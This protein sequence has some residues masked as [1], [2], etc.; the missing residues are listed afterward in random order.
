MSRN[1]WRFLLTIFVIAWALYEI[2]PPTPRDLIE[3]FEKRVEFSDANFTTIVQRAR[4]LER[5]QSNQTF[6]NLLAAVGTNDLTRYFPSLADEEDADP[7]RAILNRIQQK[8]AG[9]IKLG[10]DLQG[11]TAFLVSLD[12][13]RLAKIADKQHAVE[14]AM[15][16][17]RKRVDAF[18]VAEP[19]LQ[20]AGEGRILI[21]IPG[22]S[23]DRKQAAKETI[24]KVA[25][26]EFRLVHPE[27]DAL[28]KAEI[29]E[30]GYEL[31]TEKR[32]KRRDREAVPPATYL[33]SKTAELGLTGAY[34]SDSGVYPDPLTGSPKISL[35]FNSEGAEKFAEITRNNVG[36]QLAIV[37]DGELQSA[38]RINEPILG[39][40]CEISGDFDL[41]EAYDL[42]NVL[43]NP[44][45]T[46]VRIEEERTVDPSLG[47]DSIK[48]G[49]VAS[50]IAAVGTFLFMM[51]FYLTSGLVANLALALNVLILFGAMCAMGAT[52]TMPGIAGIALT[53]G[54]AVDAN[55]LI[56]ERMREEIA[57]G[58][59]IRGVIAG[60]YDK[61]F[62]TIFDSNLTT[63]IAAL[64]LYK[65]GTGPVKGFGVT[66]SI[67]ICVSMFTALLVT[68]L[69][70]DFLLARNLIRKVRMLPLMRPPGIP[71]MN[72]GK[73]TLAASA[74][75]IV[76][77]LGYGVGVRGKHVLGVDFA[78]GDSLT[79][80]FKERVGVDALRDALARAGMG[81][82]TIGYQQNRA[83]GHETLRI[84]VPVEAAAKAE[85]ALQAAFP[86]AGLD[87]VGTDS[88]GPTV[89]A[90]IQRS[91]LISCLLA[92][93]AILV[94]VAFR[95]E[96]SFAVAA[97]IALIHDVFI[98]LA[99]FFLAGGQLN[100]T[101]VAALLTIIGYSINDKIVIMDRI[102]E[103]LKLGVRGTFRQVIDLALNQTLS[104]TFITGGA[105]ILSTLSLL[106]FGGGVI[107]DLAFTFL[108]GTLAGTYSSLLIASPIVLWW[109]KGQRPKLGAHI[110]VESPTMTTS[111]TAKATA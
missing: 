7:N 83:T 78:G 40:N 33:V 111:R 6:L 54:M 75:V 24:Q 60:G 49:M 105:V 101:M 50:A 81:D 96:F 31:M 20:P 97:V 72:W 9:R 32:R 8:A 4:E 47:A 98:T 67:G 55:V 37:L 73:A 34:V 39:G 14:Q 77:G 70:Y 17:L 86:Q 52:L 104:R 109:H 28:V 3:V 38:P 16:V 1:T 5:Q 57:A 102:R 107:N 65:F 25:Y 69:L 89:G 76:L 2:Y 66:L 45:E 85:A 100:A 21:Q 63:L 23:E 99:I 58:K 15:E 12:P 79:L 80:T 62:G 43:R 36:R 46:P 26:L 94:Y 90:Q 68:R 56:Y 91:A 27:S 93:F 53:I 84:T 48:S 59:S 87:M 74:V 29:I 18:G 10:L 42:A 108:V 71:F 41:R 92:L 44:L 106:I 61:A 19:I 82:A 30:P 103:D 13:E 11:G 35:R 95:Y 51:V 110:E 88:I 64:I 22:M